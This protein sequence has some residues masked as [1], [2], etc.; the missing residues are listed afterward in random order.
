MPEQKHAR[1]LSYLFIVYF[2]FVSYLL[3]L[4]PQ[5]AGFFVDFFPHYL[6]LNSPL[7]GNGMVDE[8]L[9]DVSA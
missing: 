6:P 2:P 1:L 8:W 9:M 3:M 7:K 4:W 5:D